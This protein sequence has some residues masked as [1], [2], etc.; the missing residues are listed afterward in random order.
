LFCFIP[1]E[2]KGVISIDGQTFREPTLI[3]ND[4]PLDVTGAVHPYFTPRG[5]VIYEGRLEWTHVFTRDHFFHSNNSWYSLQYG[6]AWDSEFVNYNLFRFLYN[7]DCGSWLS[8]G[9]DAHRTISNVYKERGSA[10]SHP[11]AAGS[12]VMARL[13]RLVPFQ[14]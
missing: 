2:L 3:D 14:P 10:L 6:I 4:N 8:V 5:F 9:F 13:P 7:Q 12:L 1:T 11:S